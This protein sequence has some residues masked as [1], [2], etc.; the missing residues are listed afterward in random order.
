MG[1]MPN[2]RQI[3]LAPIPLFFETSLLYN[4]WVSLL[5]I[6]PNQ[7]HDALK[8]LLVEEEEQTKRL[9]FGCRAG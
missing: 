3:S 7:Y 9:K 1:K 6:I 2:H 4:L 5:Y 8:V